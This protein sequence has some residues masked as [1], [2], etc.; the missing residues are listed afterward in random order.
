MKLIDV[1]N[2]ANEL[3]Q[4]SQK[5]ILLPYIVAR[6]INKN[7]IA[8]EEERKLF[9]TQRSILAKDYDDKNDEEKA[10]IDKKFQE[11]LQTEVSIELDKIPEN[12]ISNDDSLRLT[13]KDIAILS[14]FYMED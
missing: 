11:L 10:I 8:L 3:H 6:T 7:M 5:E 9:E 13:M 2:M 12:L 1:L 14:K 4:F